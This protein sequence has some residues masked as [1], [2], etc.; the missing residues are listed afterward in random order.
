ML[1]RCGLLLLAALSLPACGRNYGN[2]F[3]AP[4][5]RAAPADAVLLFLS[6]SWAAEPGAP[7]ELFASNADGSE[8]V[9]LTSCGQVTPPCNLVRVAVSEDRT[10]IAAIRS[11]ADA[12][13][14]DSSLFFMDLA[15]SVE[16]QLFPQRR[17]PA[18][19][20]SPD[21][22]LLI[23]QST[24]DQLSDDD[25]LF[26]CDP[27][28]ANDR[29]V[30]MTA[31]DGTPVRQRNP[32]FDPYS[33]NAVYERIDESGVSR[34]YFYRET[35]LTS[36]PASGPALPGTLY[37]V[38]SDA[39]PDYSP[40]GASV[41]FRRLTGIGNGGLGTWD[42]M[43]IKANTTELRPLVT[44]PAFRGPADWGT[45]GIV[46]VETDVAAD[47]SRLVVVQ[48]DGTDRTV[49]R[50]EAAGYRMAAPRWLPGN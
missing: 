27:N 7:R 30:T 32:R 8:I 15:R 44:G 4:G 18:V 14:A 39:D 36:G 37:L 38:G 21:G 49:L 10:R 16:R 45:R 26:V 9:R 47:E 5:T 40:D 13:D 1:G 3:T 22:T 33:R 34:I 6:A 2:P 23:Y 43:T 42:L 41:V 24:G 20:W 19:D 46:F 31:A 25:D 35:P 12:A 29:D 11:A 28:G 17:V 48:P 50:T